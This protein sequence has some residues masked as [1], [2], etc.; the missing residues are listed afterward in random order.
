[1]TATK[2]KNVL[3]DLIRFRIRAVEN[4]YWLE[5]LVLAHLFVETQLRLIL[6]GIPGPSGKRIAKST[7][8]DQK[9]VMQLANLAKDSGVIDEETWAMIREFNSARNKAVHDLSSG[10]ITYGEL[11]T[12]ALS[13]SDLMS[14]LQRYYVAVNIGPE[15]RVGD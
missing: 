8:D 10:E 2:N 3:M 7:I 5:A 9:Y 15:I 11:E 12:P 4:G 1:M 6:W 14:R 13:A